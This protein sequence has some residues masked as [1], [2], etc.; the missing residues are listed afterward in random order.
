M[1]VSPCLRASGAQCSAKRKKE[2]KRMNKRTS[3]EACRHYLGGGCCQINLEGECREGG[4]FEAWKPMEPQCAEPKMDIAGTLLKWASIAI[5][6]V[7]YP[8]VLYRIYQWI[9]ILFS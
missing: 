5:C 8:F 7:A 3:C 9:R 4:G 2:E 6:M 1:R